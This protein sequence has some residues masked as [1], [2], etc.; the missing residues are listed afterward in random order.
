M[1]ERH[2]ALIAGTS[3]SIMAFSSRP[4]PVTGVW[5]P[6]FDTVLAGLWLIDAGQSA[7][8]ALLDH[9]IRWH[10]GGGEPAA[11]THDRIM[12][13]VHV[14]RAA[15]GADFAANLHVLPD[16]HGN[17]SPLADPRATGVISG[18]DLDASFDSLCRLYWRAAV[19]IAL[20][21]RHIID[22]LDASSGFIDRL[23][24]TGGH[25][26]NPLLMELYSEAIGCTL[27]ERDED[28]GVL[29]GTAAVAAT[30]AGLHTGLESAASAVSPR[31]RELP[32]SGRNDDRY[33]RDYQVFLAMH[34]QRRKLDT[35]REGFDAGPA[36]V[37]R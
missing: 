17:R 11:G 14:L 30:A 36:S 26:R 31:G 12:A 33:E 9:L 16:F 22:T 25:T 10:G 35:I 5:G 37:A 3:S 18:L 1:I 4:Q 15:E 28:H 13:R 2:V 20:G 19:G 6:F 24:V 7:T 29:S 32:V 21:V 27:M 8:G 23:H 34:D